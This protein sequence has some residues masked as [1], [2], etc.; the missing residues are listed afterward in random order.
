M[1]NSDRTQRG[2]LFSGDRNNNNDSV[3]QSKVL[4]LSA[5]V[6]E[7]AYIF[8]YDK[9]SQLLLSATSAIHPAQWNHWASF[10]GLGSSRHSNLF[11]IVVPYC[12]YNT[13]KQT[14]NCH[15]DVHSL[16]AVYTSLVYC[17][18]THL[19]YHSVSTFF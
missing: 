11:I 18:G 13:Q 6:N 8:K 1:L 10:F 12:D 17:D 19:C 7:D 5:R 16:V 2:S 4:Y 14:R 3:C 15:G 9:S